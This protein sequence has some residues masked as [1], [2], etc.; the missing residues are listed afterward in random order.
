VCTWLSRLLS[1]HYEKSEEVTAVSY[2]FKRDHSFSIFYTKNKQILST[3][4]LAAYTALETALRKGFS[5][6][7]EDF[8]HEITEYAARCCPRYLQNRCNS[9]LALAPTIAR[10]IHSM[11]AHGEASLLNVA[12]EFLNEQDKALIALG[13]S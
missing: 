1:R 11:V 8:L 10:H 6:S 3:Q 9:I 2:S 4:D 13:A 7:A 12:D 5:I